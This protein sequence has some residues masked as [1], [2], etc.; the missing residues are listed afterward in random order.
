[1]KFVA[2]Y[3]KEGCYAELTFVFDMNSPLNEADLDNMVKDF[4][5]SLSRWRLV[6]VSEETP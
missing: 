5:R 3:T 4:A 6:D 2:L 1:M